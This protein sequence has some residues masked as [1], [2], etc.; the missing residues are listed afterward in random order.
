[1]SEVSRAYIALAEIAQLSRQYAQGLPA[2]E[3][4]RAIWSGVGFT[5]KES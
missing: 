1:M 3:E 2:Q 4:A 5:L